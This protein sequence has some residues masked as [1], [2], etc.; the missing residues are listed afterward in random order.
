MVLVSAHKSIV[1]AQVWERTGFELALACVFLA[2]LLVAAFVVVGRIQSPI[3]AIAHA[4]EAVGDGR[5]DVRLAEAGGNRELSI[6]AQKFNRMAEQRRIAE[7]RQAKAMAGLAKSEE[8]LQRALE[9]SRLALWD[10][11]MASGSVYLSETWSELVGGPPLPTTT[12]FQALIALTPAE[13]RPAVMAAMI[14]VVKGEREHYQVEH[15]VQR[16]DGEMIWILSEGRVIERGPD[17]RA[18]RAVGTNRDITERKRLEQE[19]RRDAIL[20]GSLPIA[21]G[22][23]DTAER[24][25]YANRMYRTLFAGS[26]EPVGLTVR[27]MLGDDSYLPV[28]AHIRRALAGEE[29]QTTRPARRDD[30]SI[31]TRSIRYVP[32]RDAAGRVAGFFALIE[33]VTELKRSEAQQRLAASV[34]D[35]ANE[36]IL[37]TDR[38]N[39][40][41]SVNRAFT[42]ITGYA[43]EEAIGK[44]PSMLGSGRQSGAFYEAMWAS[45]R[46]TGRWQGEVWDQRK[47]GRP[48]CELLSIAAIRDDRGSIV[49]HCAIFS[50]ITRLKQT[51]A[52]LMALNAQLEDRVARRTVALDHANRE[53]ESFSYSVSHDLRTPLRHINGFAALLLKANKDKLDAVSVDHL[54]RIGAASERMGRLIADLLELSRVSR[55]EL[56]KQDIDLSTMAGEVIDSLVQAHPERQVRITLASGMR[57]HGDPGLL[58][59]VLENLLGN[60]WK[61]TARADRPGIEVGLEERQGEPA[62]CVRDN[63]AGFDMKYAGKLF[64]AFQRLHAAA[65]FEGTGIGLSIV[66]RIVA[67][68]GGRIAAEGEPGKG[69]AFYFTLGKDAPMV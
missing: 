33:D 37:I 62:Y 53:L 12:T 2:V 54:Q 67:R 43:P 15:R 63:G 8:R 20:L 34:F 48:Y 22:H 47:D 18:L 25:T 7:T 19:H 10:Y 13:D 28:A 38:D 40:I 42:E 69:A 55:Q 29:S 4:A 36:G 41:L 65:E 21:I 68:H 5:F 6:L 27:D 1:E 32:E 44:N 61:F 60:A 51:E 52:E 16:Q 49:R 3:T 23:A 26:R 50:D 57:A 17:G 64:G 56:N 9:A 30:G 14:P 66:Q 35:N 31:G 24:I 11:D 39:H 45:I 58:R 46:E 59:I